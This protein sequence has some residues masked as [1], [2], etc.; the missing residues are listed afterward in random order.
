MGKPQVC[1]SYSHD[2]VYW[3]GRVH[4]QLKA[5]AKAG[6]VV[7]TDR[8]IKTGEPWFEQVESNL[9]RS[10]AAVL[11]VS[12]SFLASDFIA[13]HEIPRLRRRHKKKRLRIYPLIVKDCSWQSHTWL[14]EMQ[15][16]PRNG[17]PLR[18]SRFADQELK[19]L[20]NEVWGDLE[21]KGG[22]KR[23]R[24]GARRDS[25][26][27]KRK[28][29]T[30]RRPSAKR[31]R[32]SIGVVNLGTGLRSW[33]RT[34]N[35]LNRVQS[36]FR[37]SPSIKSL[38]RRAVEDFDG[39]PNIK[40]YRLPASFFGRLAHRKADL[41]I[42]MSR[43]FLAFEDG[44]DVSYNYLGGLA[45]QDERI[46]F[47]SCGGLADHVRNAGVSESAGIA[48]LIASHLGYYIG[49]R[50]F[51]R[52]RDCPM[53]YTPIHTDMVRGLRKGS[54]CS[55]CRKALKSPILK[56]LEAMVSVGR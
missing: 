44:G 3:L 47:L 29:P 20:A 23:P 39:S 26:G 45:P 14:E 5:H 13:K 17:K 37:F 30:R 19:D 16:R 41:V 51:H 9:E 52:L 48:Y 25:D 46:A 24:E 33:R 43:Q 32:Y 4:K 55:P 6:S 31:H 11:L 1:I 15:V 36:Y 12:A 22:V 54:F 28:T 50:N 35:E 10:V 18:G 56:A 7:W 49:D 2:D 38:P 53:D 8:Q 42:C 34:L 40:T 21:S 27:K